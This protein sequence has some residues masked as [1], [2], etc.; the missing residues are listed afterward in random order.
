MK[1]KHITPRLIALLLA[2]FTVISLVACSSGDMNKTTEPSDN[3]AWSENSAGGMEGGMKDESI[4]P[5][6]PD[7]EYDRKIIRRVDMSC[8]TKA[9]DDALSMI[10]ATLS[11]YGGHV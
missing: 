3:L 2:A 10:M 6:S 9:F 1:I 7:R 4:T 8:E 11:T 5:D